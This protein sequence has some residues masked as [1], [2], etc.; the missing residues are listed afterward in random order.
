MYVCK[1]YFIVKKNQHMRC[2]KNNNLKPCV[3]SLREVDRNHGNVLLDHLSTNIF[4]D[5]VKWIDASV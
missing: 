1:V 4:Y 3:S 2:Q 5:C